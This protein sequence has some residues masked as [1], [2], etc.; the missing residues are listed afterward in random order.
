MSG[1][2]LVMLACK[3][4]PATCLRVCEPGRQASP[5]ELRGCGALNLVN[6]LKLSAAEKKMQALCMHW[7]YKSICFC[8]EQVN[9]LNSDFQAH[10]KML[11]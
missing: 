9:C 8:V 5:V 11:I 7:L 2:V 10:H 4:C 1:Q 6:E 3:E